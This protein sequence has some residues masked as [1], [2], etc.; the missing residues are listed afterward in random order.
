MWV[1]EAYAIG[2]LAVAFLTLAG[3]AGGSSTSSGV[4][5]GGGRPAPTVTTAA[6]PELP[7]GGPAPAP[8]RHRWVDVANDQVHLTFKNHTY[9]VQITSSPSVT[10]DTTSFRGTNFWATLASGGS[11]AGVG[12]YRWSFAG[13]RLRFHKIS[14]PCSSRADIFS[15]IYRR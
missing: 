5:T 12:H 13:S 15:R 4:G 11:C 7:T 10:V 6:P 9:E 2:T 14:D 1:R 3:C 8:L